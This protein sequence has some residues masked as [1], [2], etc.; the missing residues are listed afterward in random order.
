MSPATSDEKR[1]KF[2]F[3]IFL[4]ILAVILAA[5]MAAVMFCDLKDHFCLLGLKEKSEVLKYL[6]VCMGGVLV[7]IQAVASH[8]RAK[9][10][11][12]AVSAQA[13]AVEAQARMVKAQAAAVKQHAKANQ[14]TERGLRQER[15]KDAIGHLGHDSMSVRI[16][17]AYELF[18]LAKETSS[19]RYTVQDI[20]C[21]HIKQTTCTR[22]YRRQFRTEP[23]VEVES[24]LSLL[25][26]DGHSVFAEV[27]AD[28][29]G[30]YLAGANL[31]NAHLEGANL[32]RACL[33]DAG[34]RGAS[35]QGALLGATHLQ[36]AN[37]RGARLQG[38]VLHSAAL[39]CAD[40]SG[41]QC[42]G[43]SIYGAQ[44]QA[45]KLDDAKLHGAKAWIDYVA[46]DQKPPATNAT[47][48]DVSVGSRIPGFQVR[49]QL[50]VGEKS[51]IDKA[52]FE[53]GMSQDRIDQLSVSLTK[54]NKTLLRQ[55]MSQH[56]DRPAQRKPREGS[57]ILTGSY[58]DE[59]AEQWI[60]N[61][62]KR[63]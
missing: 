21:G 49:I 37:L 17:S 31:R 29:S 44:L 41:A 26:I 25:F 54:E 51:R 38:A 32:T 15:L 3:L 62:P 58:I 7:A 1:S 9:A 28:L 43:L 12:D 27:K 6:G 61:Y 19:Y 40:L 48:P 52:T 13:A 11:E 42:Q 45:A 16:G 33:S 60:R 14:H 23:S 59:E 53:G 50:S 36:F 55:R 10:M 22:A 24:I 56:L 8:R 18:H 47:S 30:S 2:S 4:V 20:L 46:D 63:S 39:Q 34:L 5:I 35:L 57:G